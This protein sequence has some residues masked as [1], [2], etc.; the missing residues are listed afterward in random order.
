MMGPLC[1]GGH[2]PFLLFR[3]GSAIILADQ[4]EHDL[5]RGNVPV[6]IMP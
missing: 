2:G 6:H 5:N 4:G 1:A 3:H